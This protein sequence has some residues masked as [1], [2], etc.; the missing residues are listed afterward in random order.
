MA[1]VWGKQGG[2][3]SY[4]RAYYLDVSFNLKKPTLETLKP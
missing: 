1:G 2:V 4:P 3:A